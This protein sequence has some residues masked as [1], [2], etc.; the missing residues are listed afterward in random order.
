MEKKPCHVQGCLRLVS[1][2]PKLV[3]Y[4]LRMSL[5]TDLNKNTHL[6]STKITRMIRYE[7]VPHCTRILNLNDQSVF[8]SRI[9]DGI[10][11]KTGLTD[12]QTA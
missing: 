12:N 3:P 8:T 4:F 1:H 2:Y 5:S 6:S 7:C 10:S 9:F 11:F